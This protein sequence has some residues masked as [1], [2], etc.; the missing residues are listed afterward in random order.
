MPASLMWN[1][2]RARPLK[3]GLPCQITR[4]PSGNGAGSS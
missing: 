1:D 3:V 2:R 4:S